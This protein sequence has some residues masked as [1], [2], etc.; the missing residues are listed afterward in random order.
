MQQWNMH[1][2]PKA[3]VFNVKQTYDSMCPTA[4]LAGRAQRCVVPLWPL[5]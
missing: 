5:T 1:D 3:V 4:F 2:K